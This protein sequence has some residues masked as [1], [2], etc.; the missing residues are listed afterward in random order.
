MGPPGP[1]LGPRAQI[2]PSTTP[3]SMAT[4]DHGTNAHRK[5]VPAEPAPK[6][7]AH[8]EH[9]YQQAGEWWQR[10]QVSGHRAAQGPIPDSLATS[11]TATPKLPEAQQST[12]NVE[13]ANMAAGH[14]A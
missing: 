1:D 5:L 12:D 8:T 4:G 14:H 13:Q 6:Q 2:W 9:G 3:A 7:P 11:T 10:E